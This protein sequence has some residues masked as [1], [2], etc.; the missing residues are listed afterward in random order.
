MTMITPSYLGETIEYS[1]LHACRSTLEDPTEDREGTV[2]AGGYAIPAGRLCAIQNSRVQCYGE[3]GSLGSGVG[4]LYEDS[5]GNLWAAASGTA[6]LWRWKPG[7]PKGY[8]MPD[9]VQGLSEVDNG[10]LLISTLGGIRQLIGGRVEMYMLP[11]AGRQF[12]AGR[13]LL[14]RDGGL[15]IGTNGRGLLHVHQGRTDLFTRSDGLSGDLAFSVFEDR[16]GDIWVATRDGL[17]RFRDFAIPTISVKQGLSNGSV[18]SVLAARDGSLWVGTLDGLNRWNHWR[19]TIYRNRNSRLPDD[20]VESLFQDDQGRIWASTRRGVAYS[21]NGRFIP[22]S[23]LPGGTVHSIAGDSAGNLWI[24]QDH[25]LFHLLQGSVVELIPWARLGRK[26]WAD[27]LFP[28]PV[29]GGLWLGFR[30][31]GLAYLKDGQVR[32]SY[33]GADGLE[34]FVSGLQLDRDG[35]LWAATQGG[36]SRTKNGRLGTL[37]SKNGLPCDTVLWVMEDDD[38]SFWLE[39]A[40]G[41]VRIARSELDAWVADPRRTIQARVFDSSDG[42]RIRATPTGSNPGVVKADGKLWFVAGDGV[43]VIDPRHLNFDK[44]P[45]P[46]HIEQITADRKIRWQNFWGAAA[47]N[48]RLPALSRDLEIDYTALSLV[49]PEKNQFKY[50]LEGYDRDWQNAGNRRQAFYTNLSPRNYRFRVIASNNNGVWNEAGASLDFS[51]AAAYYQTRWFLAACAAAIL[52]LLWALYRYRLYQIKREFNANLEGRVDERL[53]VA[54]D[55]HDTL[56]QS[57]H[58]LLFRFQAVDNL[59][60]ARPGEAKQTLESA[61]DNAAQAITEARDTVHELRSSTVVTNDLAAAVT[62]LGAELAAHHA[63]SSPSQ[64]SPTILVEVEGTPQDLH[65]ILR[66]EIYRIAGEAVRNAFSHARARRIEVEIR[67][68]DRGLRVRI[69]DDGSGIDPSVLSHEGRAGHWGLTG[70]RERA[71]RIGGNMDLWSELG[72]GTEVELRIPASIAY[73]TSAGRG[74]RLFRRKTGTRL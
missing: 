7:P 29:L 2:W 15:W 57:F 13:L 34:G 55:L 59:L 5:R 40:C 30:E 67:Y 32:A 73:Q 62:A 20:V 53:R 56:L 74:F 72:A 31:S 16:E 45:P 58:G 9:L 66:D 19:I 28:D 3:D 46:V 71:E 48:L 39:M 14:D 1:S 24:S 61:L 64:D 33:T 22:V 42:V 65:P 23:G 36:L 11:I 26:D 47:S 12:T 8:P 54:R 68:D 50:R 38:H 52:V 44:L 43:G 41:L 27:V 49:A 63:T 35:A 25:G 60:P 69:R 51:I 21:E 6:R 37:T 70:M 18:E 10:A 4:S 17:D